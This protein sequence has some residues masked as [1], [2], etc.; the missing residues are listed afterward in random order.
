MNLLSNPFNILGV[1][2]RDNVTIISD[3]ADEKSLFQDTKICNDAK[4]MLIN[5]VNRIKAEINWLPGMSPTKIRTVFDYIEKISSE[6]IDIPSLRTIFN[7]H[8]SIVYVNIEKTLLDSK[9]GL[10]KDCL[11]SIISD[12]ANCINAI[13]EDNLCAEIN[14]ARKLSTIAPI[15]DLYTLREQL[16]DYKQDCI[17]SILSSIDTLDSTEIVALVTELIDRATDTGQH[18]APD[19]IYAVVDGYEARIKVFLNKEQTRLAN[20]VKEILD[21]DFSN[22]DKK[23]VAHI[24]DQYILELKRWDKFAQ[25]IQ[26]KCM[27]RGEYYDATHLGEAA[28]Q[29]AVKLFNN[30]YETEAEK[31]IH[32]LND[33]FAE[34]SKI[35]DILNEDLTTIYGICHDREQNKKKQQEDHD[36]WVK[37]IYFDDEIGF[38][39]KDRLTL[40]ENGVSWKHDFIKLEDITAIKFGVTANSCTKNGFLYCRTNTTWIYSIGIKSA[41]NEFKIKFKTSTSTNGP[42]RSTEITEA[43]LQYNKF[44]NCLWKAVGLRLL[45]KMIEELKDGKPIKFHNEHVV[46]YNDVIRLIKPH[47]FSADEYFYCNVADI[48]FNISN[49]SLCINDPQHKTTV[50]LSLADDYN[51]HVLYVLLNL[52]KNS[53]ASKLGD[54]LN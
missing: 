33:I 14:N 52:F 29:I 7:K 54:I 50:M 18:A 36:Q 43:S 10:D 39:F 1:T 3:M 2:Q 40:N 47:F 20:K 17:S 34:V 4:N 46:V 48:T 42:F 53:N 41:L 24:A 16:Q 51:A 22:L 9:N 19:L 23:E 49:G 5:P 26:L 6:D 11:Y 21:L 45:T 44:T 37:D 8:I 25:P 13:D 31:F 15:R 35:T 12:M 28:C 38:I 27:S 32:D 30:G